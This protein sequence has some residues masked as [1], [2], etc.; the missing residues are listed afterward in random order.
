MGTKSFCYEQDFKKPAFH[1][2]SQS[3]FHLLKFIHENDQTKH[4]D[5]DGFHQTLRAPLSA[6]VLFS[7]LF[8]I[9]WR[10]KETSAVQPVW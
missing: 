8:P 3:K 2:K 10:H 4:N 7:L 6:H 9:S 5:G 1:S